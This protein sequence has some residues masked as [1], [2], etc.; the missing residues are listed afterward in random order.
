MFAKRCSSLWPKCS[1]NEALI[2]QMNRHSLV[3]IFPW[4][5]SR[6]TWPETHWPRRII[7]PRDYASR[8]L[9]SFFFLALGWE[10]SSAEFPRNYA[11]I[12]KPVSTGVENVSLPPIRQSLQYLCR[13]QIANL[14]PGKILNEND[15]DQVLWARETEHCTQTFVFTKT[16]GSHNLVEVIS[17][18]FP[19]PFQYTILESDKTLG[20]RLADRLWESAD[21]F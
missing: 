1:Q 9:R 6:T 15:R 4:Q 19:S 14:V 10:C 16:A 2:S 13:T 8:N 11:L 18:V 21:L 5:L 7:R 3:E 20:T 17:Q 12:P